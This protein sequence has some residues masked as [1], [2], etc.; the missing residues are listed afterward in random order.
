MEGTVHKVIWLSTLQ[1]QMGIVLY[2]NEDGIRS[3]RVGKVE[4]ENEHKDIVRI[5]ELGAKIS[6]ESIATLNHFV[7]KKP[8]IGI[9]PL[10][11]SQEQRL[12][13]I[14][15]CLL[16]YENAGHL[17]KKEWLAEKETLEG[18][19]KGRRT[20]NE[21]HEPFNEFTESVDMSTPQ[22]GDEECKVCGKRFIDYETLYEHYDE[23]HNKGE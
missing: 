19:V 4:G 20:L 13:E 18:I 15:D 11:L 7:V 21:V 17:P 16:R 10:W 9:K 3:A 1:G 14:K 22:K 12:Q 5:V 6:P 8:P 2:T 23:K